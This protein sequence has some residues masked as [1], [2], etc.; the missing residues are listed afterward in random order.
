MLVS[1]NQWKPLLQSLGLNS[2]GPAITSFADRQTLLEEANKFHQSTSTHPRRPSRTVRLARSSHQKRQSHPQ[3]FLLEREG[4]RLPRA[5]LPAAA[6]LG[7]RLHRPPAHPE[8][9]SWAA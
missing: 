5:P 1:S 6:A 2:A 8:T 4:S 3:S 7:S 9:L